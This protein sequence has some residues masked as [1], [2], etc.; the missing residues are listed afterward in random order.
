MAI[1][2]HPVKHNQKPYIGIRI[3]QY[4]YELH[5]KIKSIKYAFW[6]PDT[7]SWLIPY[8]SESWKECKNQLST[9]DMTIKKD[10]GIDNQKPHKNDIPSLNGELQKA[11]D[12]YYTRLYVKRYS[13]NTIKSYLNIFNMFLKDCT[14][15]HPDI[16]TKED[17]ILWIKHN[18]Q[19]YHW[20]ESYQNSVIN[21]LKFY[22]EQVKSESRSFW[23]VRPRTP[24]RL[25]GTLSRLEIQTLF[26]SCQNLKHSFILM[27][28]YSCGLRIS[29]MVNL[30][31]K[32]IDPIQSRVFIKAAK[33]KK[34]RYVVFPQKMQLIYIE[35]IR[36]YN[37]N[38]WLIEGQEGGQYSPR[39]IQNMFHTQI[40][41]AAVD[42]YATVHTLR[43]SYATHLL[44][45]GVDLRRIQEALGHNSIKTT[46]IYTH[47]QDTN[48]YRFRSPIDDMNL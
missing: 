45:L 44:E 7:K 2:I 23:E 43:H 25:P 16:W 42:S 15:R 1:L 4:Q 38:Y 11:Y 9:F 26:T 22:Y 18:L 35:Y 33:G 6:S 46:E 40:E 34:D 36:L 29:E 8:T 47:V 37:P 19:K 3:S 31:K 17:M 39:S 41:K 28:I 24:K 12:V 5:L 10:T 21:A 20:S 48:K 27:M 32:D 14:D 13:I 30:R